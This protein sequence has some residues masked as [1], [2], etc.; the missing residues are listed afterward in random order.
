[1]KH[2]STNEGLDLAIVGAGP[3]GLAAAIEAKRR[4]LKFWVLEKGCVVNS[5]FHYPVNMT[6]FTTA[7][8]LEIG[9]VPMII[10][11]EKPKRVDGL[12]YYRRV[13]DYFDLPVR[14]YEPVVSVTGEEGD[15]RVETQPRSG[16]TRSYRTQRVIV[17]TGYYDNPNRLGIPGEDLPKVSHYYAEA[18][19]Y[20]RKKVAVVGGN[21]SAAESAL[22]LYRS[23]AEVTVIHRGE[24]MGN[25]IKYWVLPDI[26][27]R[28]ERQEIAAYFNSRLVEIGERDITIA[29]PEGER[30]LENDAVFAM[31]GYRPDSSFLTGMGIRVDPETL[32]PE[33]DPETL[34]TNVKGIFL[35]GSIVSGRMTNRIFIENG[36]FHGE[37]MFQHWD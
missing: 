18:H 17:A 21:N 3:A 34:E 26:N 4:G 10:S 9:G 2:V 5:I 7:D 23:G 35:A 25:A 19:P 6:F 16:G 27:N 14:D 32:A 8:L 24:A 1:M 33:H 12:K 11:S 13:V 31:T 15:F 22:E 36:R 20:F 29:T 30:R 37:Q 28:I